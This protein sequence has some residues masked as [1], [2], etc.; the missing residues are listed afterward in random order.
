MDFVQQAQKTGGVH[1]LLP[2]TNRCFRVPF[3]RKLRLTER[4]ITIKCE[5]DLA[6]FSLIPNEDFDNFL[7]SFSSIIDKIEFG[8]YKNDKKLGPDFKTRIQNGARNA[9][10]RLDKHIPFRSKISFGEEKI[11]FAI[12]YR[13]IEIKKVSPKKMLRENHRPSTIFSQLGATENRSDI[14]K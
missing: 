9:I 13:D 5:K 2:G 4:E 10:L 8:Y 1:L 14:R 7:N 11:S 12:S 3:H 6:T